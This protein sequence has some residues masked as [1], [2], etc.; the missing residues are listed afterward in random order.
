MR[1]PAHHHVHG[2]SCRGGDTATRDV[3][4]GGRA[5][6]VG[7]DGTE[8]P[9]NLMG[10]ATLVILALTGQEAGIRRADRTVERGTT[11]LLGDEAAKMG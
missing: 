7:I 4:D 1:A 2:H 11:T 3:I 6:Q 5:V 10:F 8:T 9:F